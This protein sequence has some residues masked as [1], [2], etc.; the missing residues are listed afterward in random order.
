[1]NEPIIG[2]RGRGRRELIS[3]ERELNVLRC[4]QSIDARTTPR[5]GTASDAV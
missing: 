2:R 5:H 1:V 4:S 3:D